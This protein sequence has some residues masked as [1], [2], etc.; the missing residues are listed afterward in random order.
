MSGGYVPVFRTVFSGSLFGQYPDT[1]AWLFMLTLADKNGVID[2]TPEYIAG[3]TGMPVDVVVQCIERF[4]QPDPSSRTASNEGRRLELIDPARPWGWRIL[5][6][7]Q[8]RER[9]RKQAWDAKRTASGKDAK[10]KRAKR[11]KKKANSPSPDKSRRVPTVP[12]LKQKQKQIRK[13]P[14]GEGARSRARPWHEVENL[15]LE[16]WQTWLADRRARRLPLYKT[17]REAKKLAKLPHDEQ[18]KCVEYS[19]DRYIGLFP[20]NQSSKGG[21]R[22]SYAERIAEDLAKLEQNG[23]TEQKEL[24]EHAADE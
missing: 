6:F 24:I 15:N 17:T 16:A 12:A 1:A 2:V 4:L 20:E 7:K 11:A 14:S 8:Y 3:V 9:A 23:L 10:R 5:N 18:M 22:K 21:H 13:R 19:L